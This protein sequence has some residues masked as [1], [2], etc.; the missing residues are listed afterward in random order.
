MKKQFLLYRQVM[1]RVLPLAILTCHLSSCSAISDGI[2]T[3]LTVATKRS[4]S[5]EKSKE[6]ISIA[7]VKDDPSGEPVRISA[8]GGTARSAAATLAATFLLDQVE[9]GVANAAG[10][11]SVVYSGSIVKK[12]INNVRGFSL[13]RTVNS[14]NVSASNLELR[15]RKSGGAYS[16]RLISIR[17]DKAKA[18]VPFWDNDLDLVVKCELSVIDPEKSSNLPVLNSE[19]TVKG[20]EFGE[21]LIFEE[22]E[23]SY[24]TGWF[25]FPAFPAG[26]PAPYKLLITVQETSDFYKTAEKGKTLVGEKKKDWSEKLA[27]FLSGGEKE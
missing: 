4:G 13:N 15:F 5:F 21:E 24:Q 26:D 10:N 16:L 8:G 9:K 17:L 3:G 18:A 22:E 12:D 19:F 1:V 6:K 27:E 14:E 2:G 25:R 11:Y 23:A 20:L 7:E